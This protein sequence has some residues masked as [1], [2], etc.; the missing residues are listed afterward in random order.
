MADMTVA[1]IQ[2]LRPT[3]TYR[4]VVVSRGLY[5]GVATTGE[6]VFFVRYT[7][8]GNPNRSEYRLP[9]LFGTKSAAST[10]SLTE[11]RAMAAEIQSLAKQGI[12]YQQKLEDEANAAKA[13][14]AQQTAENYTLTD[15]F[16]AWFPTLHRKDEGASLT[17]VFNRDVLPVL[18][19]VKLKELEEQ[20]VRALL[21]P[22]AN[23]CANRKAIVILNDLKQ[24]FKWANGRRPWKLLVDDPTSNLKP[25]DITQSGY[26][27]V[28]RDRVLSSDEIKALVRQMPAAGLVKTTEL[29]IWIVMACCTRIGETIQAEWKDVDLV[30]GTWFIPEANT[31]GKAPQHT[32]YLSPF[33]VSKFQALRE[34][35]GYSR[36]CFPNT[37]GTG[38]VDVKS[39]TKQ[40]GDRQ[41]ALKTVKPLTNRSK[42]SDSL[43]LSKEKWTPH[44][45]R[46]TG[47]TQ[48]QTLGVEQHIIER[49]L[50]HVDPN[51]M[52]RIYQKFDYA[53]T[54]REAWMKLGEHLE[55][56]TTESTQS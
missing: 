44:D 51:R 27:E 47:A 48:L 28:E 38:H 46:R 26:E 29:A 17:R 50:N 8:K 39:P 2:A 19:T 9:R 24:M 3:E 12:C 7:V 43:V 20:H 5:I 40:I 6:K 4:K 52:Q 11:A 35:T 25:R 55:K 31:K 49:I 54:Q 22:I 13:V 45:L 10:I 34:M 15:L 33:A 30:T 41:A 23:A 37:D 21:K 16:N 32:V 42:A 36:W 56:L 18:G 1:G 53:P 14:T